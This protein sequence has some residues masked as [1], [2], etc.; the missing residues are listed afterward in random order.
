MAAKKPSRTFTGTVGVASTGN[1]GPAA[2][3]VD[4][5]VITKMFDPL[6]TH[7]TGEAGGIQLG[8]L[9]TGEFTATPTANKG[10]LYDSGGNLPGSI[11]NAVNVTTNINSHAISS[12]FETD[13]VT[14]KVAT[15]AATATLATTAT[16]AD[17]AKGDTRFQVSGC[18]GSDF[19]SGSQSDYLLQV[20]LVTIPYGKSLKLKRA[21]YYVSS[22]QLF[23][24]KVS[25]VTKWVANYQYGEEN[26]DVTIT[27]TPGDVSV[28]ILVDNVTGGCNI[29]HENSWWFDFAIE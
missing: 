1:N 25:T 12:I 9:A 10:V 5:D 16:L 2:L 6:A 26:L 4:T 7:D 3:I 23:K 18:A 19:T 14:A 29:S 13:G 8:N 21:R 20:F 11:A 22:G 17:A 28:S 24:I 27:S 15:L